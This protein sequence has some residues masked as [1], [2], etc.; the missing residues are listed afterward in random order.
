MAACTSAR[1]GGW[2]R[3]ST[4]ASHARGSN[5]HASVRPS[6]A[7]SA[8]AGVLT[9]RTDQCHDTGRPGSPLDFR[10][11]LAMNETKDYHHM[12]SHGKLVVA[13]LL[14][15][16][17]LSAVAS[18]SASA[19]LPCLKH[20]GSKKFALCV[21]AR[22]IE[23][24]TTVEAP[25]KLTSNL[26]LEL[27][28][29]WKGTIVCTGVKDASAFKTHGLT[30]ATTRSSRLELSGCVLQGSLASS[31]KVSTTYLTSTT[32]G[33]F[34]SLESIA[35]AP[36]FGTV[37][38]EFSFSNATGGTCPAVFGGTHAVSGEYEC[39]LG[40]AKVEAVEHELKCATNATHKLKTAG[41][42]DS[43]AYTQ[44]ISLGGTRAGQKFSIY[45][46]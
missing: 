16:I 2:A 9:G 8:S 40:E 31:C 13:A 1:S 36:E 15:A 38:F 45:E 30:A 17:V 7:S 21:A 4:S 25:A 11:V 28:K 26:V 39:K 37:L 20:E 24:T 10:S 29:Q 46:A 18:A 14:G 41:E 23:E 34:G 19:S 35:V 33:T 44:M 27:P 5:E 3:R 43:L 32:V 12:R 6:G 22:A 42:E